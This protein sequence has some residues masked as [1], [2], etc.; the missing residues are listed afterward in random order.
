MNKS[1]SFFIKRIRSIGYAFKGAY[2]LITTEASLKVQFIIGII[3]TLAGF[4]FKLSA[5][6]WIIQV[7]IIALIMALEGLNTAIEEISDFVH[8]EHHQKIGLIKDLAAGAVFIF[9]IAAIVVGCIIYIPK[10]F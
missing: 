1:E 5:T 9:A 4:Y 10:I 2:L 3:M 8:P 7:L 6:E